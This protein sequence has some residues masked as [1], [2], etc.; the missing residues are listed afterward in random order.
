[1]SL[2]QLAT[3]LVCIRTKQP[4]SLPVLV[5]PRHIEL[6]PRF[7]IAMATALC[8]L[9]PEVELIEFEKLCPLRGIASLGSLCERR[10]VRLTNRLLSQ[11]ISRSC[12]SKIVRTVAFAR[13]NILANSSGRL[14]EMSVGIAEE[15]IALP[16]WA[17]AVR[18]VETSIGQRNAG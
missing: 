8:E 5:V 3:E 18:Y 2:E 10:M 16:S 4:S 15:D 7:F 13:P 17:K 6:R 12:T 9:R 14:L 11:S 1:M